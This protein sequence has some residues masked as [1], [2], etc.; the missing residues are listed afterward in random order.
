[1]PALFG[2]STDQ[3]AP[4]AGRLQF[5]QSGYFPPGWW[6]S[7][8]PRCCCAPAAAYSAEYP[9]PPAA[10]HPSRGCGCCTAWCGKHWCSRSH[11]PCR[12]S[13]SKS[14]SCPPFRIKF[15]LPLPA[16]FRSGCGP[17]S[18]QFWWQKNK[19][20]VSVPSSA[21]YIRPTPACSAH[22]SGLPFCGTARRLR[23]RP[24]CRS[25]HPTGWSS[26]FGW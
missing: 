16:P 21:G 17:I 8:I 7:R 20:P 11:G 5:L 26:P 22:Q 15:P 14:A 24:V 23:C 18:M 1:M 19:H 10:F 6:Y 13:I 25:L 2:S 3:T 9:A 4:P 12:R